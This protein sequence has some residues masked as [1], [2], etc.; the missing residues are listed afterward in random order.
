MASKILVVDD[1][2]DL[3]LLIQQRFRKEIRDKSLEFRFASNGVEALA[4]MEGEP[5]IDIVLSD[6]NMPEMDG[7]TL[8]SKITDKGPMPKAVIVSAYGDLDNIRVAM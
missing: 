3:P 4:V 2:T 5:D 7:L 8:L 6:I 1:E